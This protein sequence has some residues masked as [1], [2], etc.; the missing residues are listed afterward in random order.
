MR[1]CG[2]LVIAPLL[3]SVFA[4]GAGS[5]PQSQAPAAR[6]DQF[7]SADLISRADALKIV[8]AS[9]AACERQGETVAA[10]VTD[11]DGHLRAALSSDGLN[12]FGL[13]S[14]NLKTATVL[15]FKAS[16]R[17][18]AERLNS[19]ATFGATYGADNRYFFHPGALPIYRNGKFVAVLAV[20]GG[21]DKDESCALE[22]L[23]L[24]SWAKTMP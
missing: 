12:A 8:D 11:A 14:A 10:F 22:A 5:Q 23:K 2:S 24:L 1:I 4:Q 19:D 20:G 18:L 16:T 6:A 21:H 9:L 17:V 13:R 3:S 7:V 15:Q